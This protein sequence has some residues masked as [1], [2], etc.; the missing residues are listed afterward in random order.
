MALFL[1][2]HWA[3]AAGLLLIA[4]ATIDLF[5]TLGSLAIAIALMAV[6][7][8]QLLLRALI[9][10]ASTGFRALVPQTCSV[11]DPYFSY[12]E[13]FWK[14]MSER[15]MM[16]F[17]G[18]PLK[19]LA[20]RLLGLR[21]GRRLFDDGCTI[22]ER[23]MVTIGDDCTLNAASVIQPHSQEDGGF[24]SNRIAIGSGCT[25]GVN[26]L[27]HYGAVMGEGC[28]LAPGSFLM[29]GEQAPPYTRWAENPAREVGRCSAVEAANAV[30]ALSQPSAIALPAFLRGAQA[31]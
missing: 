1:L 10:R 13:R 5:P 22:I 9:E 3:N 7:V 14:L 6:P 23:T 15:E 19:G 28:E 27:V 11:Y 29:K 4:F 20:W 8:F 31:R 25:L 18:T 12:H 24:K 26:S 2:M 16:P 30:P 21:I 17:D